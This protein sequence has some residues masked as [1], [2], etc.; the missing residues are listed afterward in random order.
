VRLETSD[1]RIWQ[2]WTQDSVLTGK[3][4]RL[5]ELENQL[6]A[7]P[8]LPLPVMAEQPLSEQRETLEFERG[9]FLDQ[10]GPALA[11]DVPGIFL[12]LP[13]GAVRNRLTMAQWFFA[14]GQ[15]LTARVAVNRYWEQLF[16][17]GLVETLENFGSAGEAPSHQQL[18][19]WLA[20]HFQNDLRWDMQA[21]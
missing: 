3:L 6:S 19:D 12:R 17:I 13:A 10:I 8:S 4:A 7:I 20:L 14:P 1:D 21:L 16:G 2:S 5:A 15:P 11:P 18:L 9:N